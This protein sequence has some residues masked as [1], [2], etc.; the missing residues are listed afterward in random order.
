MMTKPKITKLKYFKLQHC[1]T[2]THFSKPCKVPKYKNVPAA[3][4]VNTGTS[5][6]CASAWV[7]MEA[8]KMIPRGVMMEN[9]KK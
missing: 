4:A 1:F 2:S 5:K 6:V 9:T 3:K 8:P 7:I